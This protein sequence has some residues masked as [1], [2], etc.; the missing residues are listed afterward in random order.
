MS[1]LLFVLAW[2]VVGTLIAVVAARLVIHVTKDA[3]R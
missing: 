1:D 2:A 3:Y